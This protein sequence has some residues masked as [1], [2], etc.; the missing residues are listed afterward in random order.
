MSVRN[1]ILRILYHSDLT[2]L[3][4]FFLQAYKKERYIDMKF[5]AI[6]GLCHFET[7]VQIS[8]KVHQCQSLL[9]KQAEKTPYNY[10]TYELLRGKHL[11]PYLLDTYNYRCFREMSETVEQLYDAMPEEYT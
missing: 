11:L 7:E 6:R 8:E 4:D 9:Q 10:H 1:M 3:A 2:I 5:L